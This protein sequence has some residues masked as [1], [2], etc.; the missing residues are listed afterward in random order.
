MMGDAVS[1]LLL[2]M[3]RLTLYFVWFLR[4]IYDFMMALDRWR[5]SLRSV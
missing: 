5:A 1:Q 4:R 3:A 2:D